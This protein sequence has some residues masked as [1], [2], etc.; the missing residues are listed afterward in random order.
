MASC[1]GH[2]SISTTYKELI[3]NGGDLGG[4]EPLKRI[5][6]KFLKIVLLLIAGYEGLVARHR[7]EGGRRR[8]RRRLAVE[9]LDDGGGR[10]SRHAGV[11]VDGGGVKV[12]GWLVRR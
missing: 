11:A 2:V 8:G 12:Q 7:L 6:Q 10:T 4:I 3:L 1:V 5:H 9:G